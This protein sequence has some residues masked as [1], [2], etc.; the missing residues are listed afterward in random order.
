M[1]ALFAGAARKPSQAFPEL[2]DRER[3]VLELFGPGWSNDAIA[4]DL[5]ISNRPSNTVSP[6]YAKLHAGGRAEAIIKARGRLRPGLTPRPF[7]L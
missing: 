2:S 1:A 7:R 6:I 5:F 3:K 4:R